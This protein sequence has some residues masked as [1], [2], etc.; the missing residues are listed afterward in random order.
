[1]D[2]DKTAS[3]EDNQQNA[4][5]QNQD[6]NQNQDTPPKQE[7][8][9]DDPVLSSFLDNLL[10]TEDKQDDVNPAPEDNQDD[11]QSAKDDD[12]Q[13]DDPPKGDDSDGKQK[14]K[15]VKRRSIQEQVQEELA[16]NQPPTPESPKPKEDSPKPPDNQD[17]DVTL[18]GLSDEEQ[19]YLDLLNYAANK[20]GNKYSPERERFK[21]FVEKRNKIR[22]RILNDDPDADVDDSDTLRNFTSK[23]RPTLPRKEIRSIER[24]QIK[25]EVEVGIRKEYDQ[26]FQ[27]LDARGKKAEI[28]PQVT[29]QSSQFSAGLTEISKDADKYFEGD[30]TIPDIV[31]AMEKEGVDAVKERNPMF[32]EIVA[33][34]ISNGTEAAKELI[35][36]TKSAEKGLYVYDEKN[37]THIWLTQFIMSQDSKFASRTNDPRKIRTGN[38]GVRRTFVP[39]SDFMAMAPENQAKHWTFSVDERLRMI[40]ANTVMQ[41]RHSVE[42]LRKKLEASGWTRKQIDKELSSQAPN[43]DNKETSPKVK[44]STAPGPATGK[45]QQQSQEVMSAEERATFGL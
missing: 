34:S 9:A 10:G 7:G 8:V 26:R 38:D 30:K 12:N 6:Q 29:S 15:V 20:D 4:D 39:Q 35:R 41:M 42:G 23:N 44:Q 11:D 2:P 27:D 24:M 25:D 19:D 14:V 18:D 32:A 17:Q 16:K 28:E 5:D 40:Q 37:P 21:A 22:D 3:E 36:L 45:Q 1:M 33:E 13:D 31:E 43:K